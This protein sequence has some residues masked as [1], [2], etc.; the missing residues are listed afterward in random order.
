MKNHSKFTERV[1]DESLKSVQQIEL[2]LS[3]KDL[4]ICDDILMD[5]QGVMNSPSDFAQH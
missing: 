5:D 2:K 4:E 1:L 3:G